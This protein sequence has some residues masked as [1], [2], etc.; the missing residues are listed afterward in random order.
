MRLLPNPSPR[1]RAGAFTLIELLVVIAII[2]VLIALLLPAVQ[3]AREAARRAHCLNNLKQIG[4][5]IHN[6]AE[7]RGTLPIGQG[8]EPFGEYFGWS[9]LTMMLPFLEQTP[10]YNGINFDIP[11]GSAPGTPENLTVQNVNVSIFFCP[12]DTD[13]LTSPGGHNNYVG[14]TG[15]GPDTNGAWPSGVICGSKMYVTGPYF[16]STVIRLQD[17]TDGLSQT[18]AFSECVKGIG[19]YND[20]QTADNLSPPGSVLRLGD[21]PTDAEQVYLICSATD[22]HARNAPLAGLYSLGSFWHIGTSNATRYN[23]VMPPNTWSCTV[24]NTDNDGAHTASSR[25]PGV[26]NCFFADGSVRSVK[27]TVNR[28]SWRALGTRAGGEVV[29]ASDY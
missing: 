7:S 17:I 5:A 26:V 8:P 3:A 25:H 1:A 19:L 16:N 10:L 6:Y 12:S 22:P 20:G 23:H 21:L 9:S 24:E 27:S 2:G 4:L 13:R 15:A 28:T 14:N 18:A 11:G 29:S